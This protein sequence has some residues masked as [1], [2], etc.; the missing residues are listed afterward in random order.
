MSSEVRWGLLVFVTALLISTIPFVGVVLAISA[1]FTNDELQKMCAQKTIVYNQQG[2]KIGE[3]LREGFCD[4]YL[5]ATF[6]AIRT[7]PKI[8][9]G[10]GANEE[11]ST[12]YLFSIYETY[13]RDHCCPN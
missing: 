13:I 6:H 9:C 4:G 8:L 3:K 12:E 11:K 1:D 5:Q 7:S 2:I 10:S